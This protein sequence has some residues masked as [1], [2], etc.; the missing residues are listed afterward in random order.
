VTDD[1]IAKLALSEAIHKKLS[2]YLL[3]QMQMTPGA[4]PDAGERLVEGFR[5]ML[6]ARTPMHARSRDVSDHIDGLLDAI[7]RAHRERHGR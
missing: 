3:D 7:L 1:E 2:E 5:S 4:A 6:D